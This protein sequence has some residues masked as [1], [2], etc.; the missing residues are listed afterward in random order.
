MDLQMRWMPIL[1]LPAL[2]LAACLLLGGCEGSDAR[3]AVDETVKEL[4]GAGIV[5]KGQEIEQRVRE[6]NA[7]D[8][9]RIQEDISRG[10]YGEE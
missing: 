9:E 10:V 8:I 5:E 1:N 3:D 7:R 2:V 6:L 4:S